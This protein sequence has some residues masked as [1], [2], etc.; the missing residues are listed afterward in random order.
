LAKKCLARNTALACVP[1]RDCVLSTKSSNAIHCVPL[2]IPHY[3]NRPSFVGVFYALFLC[4]EN[5]LFLKSPLICEH[6]RDL[7]PLLMYASKRR[8]RNFKR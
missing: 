1:L 7:Y 3:R 6:E 2:R 8:Q 4:K 5:R